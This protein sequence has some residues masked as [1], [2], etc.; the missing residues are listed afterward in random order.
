MYVFPKG[1]EAYFANYQ[2][3]QIWGLRLT[4]SRFIQHLYMQETVGAASLII[5]RA[6]LPNLCTED[7]TVK[8]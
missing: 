7:S 1:K 2:L 5:L 6:G 4:Q 3:L 8:P